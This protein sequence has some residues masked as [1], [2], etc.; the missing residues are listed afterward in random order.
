MQKSVTATLD[1]AA[2]MAQ[3]ARIYKNVEKY[4]G[5]AIRMEQAAEAAFLWALDNPDSLSTVQDMKSSL[6][7]QT[8]DYG[9]RSARMNFFGNPVNCT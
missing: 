1:F 7:I 3:A 9:D 8:G 4:A 2:S 5:P 6:A